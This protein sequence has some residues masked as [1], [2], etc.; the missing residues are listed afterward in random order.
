MYATHPYLISTIKSSFLWDFE[1]VNEYRVNADFNWLWSRNSWSLERENSF[2]TCSQFFNCMI[3]ETMSFWLSISSLSIFPNLKLCETRLY[4][5]ISR[6]TLYVLPD[7]R[8]TICISEV[9]FIKKKILCIVDIRKKI[10]GC[11]LIYLFLNFNRW[12][13]H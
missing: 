3:H 10:I 2:A 4:S 6:Q 7:S 9:S 13:D 1:Y 12:L 11:C 5:L 8:H